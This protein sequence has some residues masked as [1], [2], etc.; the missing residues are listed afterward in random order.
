MHN[1]LSSPSTPST[2][3]PTVFGQPVLTQQTRPARLDQQTHHLTYPKHAQPHRLAAHGL[4]HHSTHGSALTS[5]RSPLI[6][7]VFPA[8]DSHRRDAL[9]GRVAIRS[10]ESR[11]DEV[12]TP[13]MAPSTTSRA[14]PNHHRGGGRQPPRGMHSVWR[15]ERLTALRC[16]TEVECD[17]AHRAQQRY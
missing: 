2:P 14:V 8:L 17:G 16:D 1:E 11:V 4:P 3:P 10:T 5:H 15:A 9:P 12:L 7:S 6:T 13:D